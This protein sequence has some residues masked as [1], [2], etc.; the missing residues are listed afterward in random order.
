[1]P[2]FKGVLIE[3]SDMDGTIDLFTNLFGMATSLRDGNTYA[4]LVDESG[5]R[6]CLSDSSDHPN[7]GEIVLLAKTRNMEETLSMLAAS[8]DVVADPPIR[9]PHEVR[10][11]ARTTG[12]VSIS[13]YESV[14]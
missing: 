11:L 6:L 13:I 9:G 3:T 5:G 14:R 8:G 12:G 1:M 10:A 4:E 7:P 2:R